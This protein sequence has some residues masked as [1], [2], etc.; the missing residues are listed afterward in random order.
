MKKLIKL[1][2]LA[3][4]LTVLAVCLFSAIT[5]SAAVGDVTDTIYT[6]D[7]Q[8]QV[9]GRSIKGYAIDGETLIAL[10]DLEDY[11]FTVY[12]NDNIRSVFVTKTGSVD[13]NFNPYIPRGEV[14][15]TAGYV[16]E[17]DIKAYLNGKQIE[18]YAID[19]QM[20]AK[21]ETMGMDYENEYS[22]YIDTR[23]YFM[24]YTYDDSQRLLSLYT[25][26]SDYSD[27]ANLASALISNAFLRDRAGLMETTN[28]Y[29]VGSTWLFQKRIG[30]LPHG[31]SLNRHY[32]LYDSGLWVDIYRIAQLYYLR[33]SE[34]R[35]ASD[36]DT[37]YFKHTTTEGLTEYKQIELSSLHVFPASE[38]EYNSALSVM[39]DSDFSYTVN[40]V[41]LPAYSMGGKDYLRLAD[42]ENC[43]FRYFTNGYFASA[44]YDSDITINRNAVVNRVDTE[45]Y[46]PVI[47]DYDTAA[48]FLNGAELTDSDSGYV[49]RC[50][51]DIFVDA[52]DICDMTDRGEEV[53][54]SYTGYGASKGCHLQGDL[55]ILDSRFNLNSEDA[56]YP[57]ELEEAALLRINSAQYDDI[58]PTEYSYGDCDIY[59]TSDV[60]NVMGRNTRV[61]YAYV[62]TEDEIFMDVGRMSMYYLMG[63][64]N[65]N[66]PG[67]LTGVEVNERA[68]TITFDYGGGLS[69][70]MELDEFSF[71]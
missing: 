37:V 65:V 63:E 61:Y 18:A 39:T 48:V 30:G 42:F 35:M 24:S 55:D 5:A 10:E 9:D 38:A 23:P 34:Y 36:G 44:V 40:G 15:G 7:I 52:S 1:S 2:I 11:G 60:M 17:T 32:A 4:S 33:P 45:R 31:D 67:F 28:Y 13:P 54:N 51:D 47:Q 22:Y 20:V 12:Y 69:C 6:T 50:G 41:T 62:M 57:A 70:E 71:R 43:G 27:N 66:D 14:G 68:G 3:G 56:L 16:Y 58:T 25:N 29:R 8:T 46:R 53:I 26:V 19:G 21:V 64:E 59:V 49:I